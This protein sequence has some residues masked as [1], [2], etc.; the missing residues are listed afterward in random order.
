LLTTETLIVYRWSAVSG[1]RGCCSTKHSAE[2]AFTAQV[3][4][5]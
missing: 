4:H 2:T 1:L 3:V 5:W